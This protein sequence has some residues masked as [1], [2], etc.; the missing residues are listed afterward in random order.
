MSLLGLA[1][2][3]GTRRRP[4]GP[5]GHAIRLFAAGTA[6]WTVYAAAWSKGDALSLTITF[7]SLM[8]VMTFLLIGPSAKSDAEQVKAVDLL[9]A[10][11]SAACGIYF[12]TEA[13]A[14]AVRIT[15]LDPLSQGDVVFGSLLILLAIEAMRRTVGLGLT[16][17]VCVFILY[18]LF[19]D[20]LGGP[21]KHGEISLAHFLDIMVLTTDGLFGVPLRVAATYAFLFVM[22]G[23]TLAKTGGADF[24]FNLAA[25]LTGK[26]RGGP[27]K[28]AVISSALYGTISGSPTSDVVTTG[29]VTI[30]MMKKLG[31]KAAFAGAVE[32]AASTGGSL[33]P[34]VMG[35]AAFIMAEYT[36]IPYVE[37]AFAAIIPALLYYLPIYLQVH[38]RAERIGLRGMTE[39][40]I[41]SVRKTL[42]EGG[43]F[44]VPLA[45][46]T[47]SLVEGY[48]PTYA[49]LYGTG[50][51]LIV[52]S[53]RRATRLNPRKIYEILAETSLRMVAVAGACA[54]AGLVIGGIT[55]TGLASKFSNLVFLISGANQFVSLVLA[56]LLTL[57]LGLGMPT[58]SAYI[59]AAVLVAP[60]MKNLGIEVMAGHLFLL[61]FAV[62]SAIT[63]PV[64]VAAY[65]ASAIADENPLKIAVQAV[66]IALAAFFVPFAF[67]YSPALLLQGS[68]IETAVA[69]VTVAAALCLLVVAAEGYWKVAIGALSR[70]ALLAAGLLL[71]SVQPVAVAVG[72]ALFVLVVLFERRG[73]RAAA[74]SPS[75]E[76]D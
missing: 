29:A 40:E 33:L 3:T 28:I 73:L 2:D 32:V 74:P 8:L 21:L 63:P 64:A 24:F 5:L 39:D 48:T 50:A 70:L 36:G 7:L 34:P 4:Q 67:V 20:R 11:L 58:P 17:I 1:F 41:P 10:L 38:L 62:M 56:G 66:R 75:A 26:T 25:S 23:T 31:Y 52:S 42:R 59:L 53:L 57:L 19:G 9:L 69:T 12:M 35:A 15:L 54:A 76:P 72:V 61:Y 43:L 16:A 30:P 18:N 6:V 46:I 27:A 65:A 68:W 71:L 14:I 22:F 55:M 13:D 44:L 49:A 51:V 45:V 60:V 37:I 47:W